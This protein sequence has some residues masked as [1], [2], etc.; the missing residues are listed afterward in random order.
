MKSVNPYIDFGGRA[1]EALAFYQHCFGGEILAQ[2]TYADAKIDCPPQFA[3]NVLHSEFRS[4]AIHLMA[5]DG[6][7]DQPATVGNNIMLSLAFSDAGEQEQTFNA[8]A[9]GGSVTLPLHDAF[10]GARFGMLVD[11]FGI[12]WMLNCQK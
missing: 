11:R 1:R 7:A 9:E 2:M 10:W 8:L 12:H 5:S 4:D 6:R 3:N